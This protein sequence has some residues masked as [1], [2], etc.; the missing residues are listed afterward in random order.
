M[1]STIRPLVRGDL[2]SVT[3]LIHAHMDAFT[4][5]PGFVEATLLDDPWTPDPAPALVATDEGRLVGFLGAQE[6]RMTFDESTIT[7][8][9]VSQFVVVPDRRASGVATQLLRTLLTGEQDITWA[10]GAPEVVARMWRVLGGHVDHARGCDWMVVLRPRPWL[11]RVI[12][13]AP[14][15]GFPRELAPVGAVPARALRPR[16]RDRS[17]SLDGVSGREASAAE[18]VAAL[19]G[20]TKRIRVRV[21]YDEQHLDH[22][23]RQ[24]RVASGGIVCR[25]V[26]R[27]G[28]EI[29]WYVY[30]T[31][32]GQ[33]S[34]VLC[35]VAAD[36][37]AETV[38]AE[39][40]T[41]AHRRGSVAISGRL[42][43]HISEAVRSWAPAIGLGARPLF[44]A[45]DPT[46]RTTIASSS[47][48]LTE[49]DS[50]DNRWL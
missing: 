4:R 20:L 18:V 33:A 26:E 25:L 23:L 42:E 10:E 34:R 30:T 17:P 50:I 14:R 11:R 22:M 24:W 15:G 31:R 1:A 5:D 49:L 3:P 8:V 37:Q 19:P 35:I 12:A 9:N 2:A 28:R 40:M 13:R 7:G 43:P 36:R 48:L 21:E 32:A 45:S 16:P 46:L 41:D 47:T 38:V 6:R 27:Q 44:H 39:L 29:G